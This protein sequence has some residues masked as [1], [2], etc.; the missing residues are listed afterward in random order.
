MKTHGRT[1]VY[2]SV[3]G[4]LA[5]AGDGVGLDPFGNPEAEPGGELTATLS[6][7][8]EHVFSAICTGCH[9]GAAAPLG[10]ALD[11]GSSWSNLVN[12]PSVQEP[13]V[14]RV[15]PG[16]PEGSYLI[17]KIEGRPTISGAQMPRGLPPLGQDQ[18][19]AIRSWIQSGAPSN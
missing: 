1:V 2:A 6:S 12:V 18:I 4:L 8:Q 10:L 7:I 14:L 19:Q 15:A 16:D 11:P 5:C 17:W 3:L 9:T 13:A